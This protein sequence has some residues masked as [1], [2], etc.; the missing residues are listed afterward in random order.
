M[1]TLT[2]EQRTSLE[3]V[4]RRT[5]AVMEADLSAQLS[6]RFGIDADGRLDDEDDLHLDP[7][8]LSARRQIVDVIEHLRTEGEDAAGAVARLLRESVFTHLNRLMAIR[9]AEDQ[10]LLAPSLTEGRRSRGYLDVL[11]LAP[12]LAGEPTGGYHGFGVG[13]TRG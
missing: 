5:R 4:V 11:E 3:R 6:G 2:A 12:P 13:Y 1:T 10:G 7:T 9:I 8:A